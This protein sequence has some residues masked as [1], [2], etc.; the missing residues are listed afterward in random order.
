[1]PIITPE[2]ELVG[3]EFENDLG[4][5]PDWADH[6]VL[7]L[8]SYSTTDDV[9]GVLVYTHGCSV[10]VKLRL[11]VEEALAAL[12]RC[13]WVAH[14]SPETWKEFSPRP[15][16]QRYVVRGSTWLTGR[17]PKNR[18]LPLARLNEGWKTRIYTLAFEV[19]NDAVHLDLQVVRFDDLRRFTEGVLGLKPSQYKIAYYRAVERFIVLAPHEAQQLGM[20]PPV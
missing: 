13:G 15:D 16:V 2:R 5:G 4:L 20:L 10:R 3:D 8:A 19:K 1:M 6:A 9:P 7:N 11:P 12:A 17:T 14:A 18:K